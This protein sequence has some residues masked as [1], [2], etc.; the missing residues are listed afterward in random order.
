MSDIELKNTK[1][2]IINLIAN[3]LDQI[4]QFGVERIGIFGSL[5]RGD[6]TKSSDIDILVE[7]H[8]S[9][10]TFDNLMDLYFFLE[11]LFGINIDL[12]TEDGLSPYSGPQILE[13]V[14]YIEES[15]GFS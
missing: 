13:E 4:K 6:T 8:D 2:K 7:F 5:V 14:E 12:V 10:K 1:E 15:N 9:K 3:N 11:K